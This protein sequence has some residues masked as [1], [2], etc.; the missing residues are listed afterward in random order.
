M[1]YYIYSVDLSN[2]ESCGNWF[3]YQFWTVGA[4]FATGFGPE[5]CLRLAGA[6]FN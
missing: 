2:P 6:F 5:Y 3:R 1:A 4:G